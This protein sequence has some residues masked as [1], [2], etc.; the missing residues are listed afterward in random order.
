MTIYKIL[1]L[2]YTN[3]VQKAAINSIISQVNKQITF[4]ST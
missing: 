3:P 1:S 2:N 4:A